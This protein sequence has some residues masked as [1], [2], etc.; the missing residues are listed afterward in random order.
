MDWRRVLLW[1]GL[2]AILIAAVVFIARVSIIA[3]GS[4]QKAGRQS[5]RAQAPATGAARA[6]ADVAA[7]P[8]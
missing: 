7:P 2:A 5:E 1:A 6:P 8:R 4:A 3:F